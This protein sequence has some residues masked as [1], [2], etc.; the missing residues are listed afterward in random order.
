MIAHAEP[1]Q[2]TKPA[3]IKDDYAQVVD[4]LAVYTEA[5]NQLDALQVKANDEF[6]ES[7]DDNKDDYAKL[8]LAL[9][10]AEEAL[11]IIARKHPEWFRDS[12]TVKTPYGSISI[13][14]NPA[15]LEV[16]SE[17][18]TIDLI[19]RAG[20]EAKARFLRERTEL[21]LDAL[22][23][24]PDEELAK[25]KIVRTRGDHFEAKPAKVDMG[26]A[27]KAADKQAAKASKAATKATK[28]KEAA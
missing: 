4:L 21:N 18:W 17:E 8:Q 20:D 16:K 26:K 11:E 3:A 2:T 15:K 5:T 9:N 24:L 6:L 13:K 7:I 10:Q 27:K 12:K 14:D 19:E 23:E 28:N 25:F 22:G 1:T